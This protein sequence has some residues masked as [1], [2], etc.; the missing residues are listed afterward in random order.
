MHVFDYGRNT[1]L[2]HA[3]VIRLYHREDIEESL[4]IVTHA[5][6]S[7]VK[8]EPLPAMMVVLMILPAYVHTN[9]VNSTNLSRS[10]LD[11]APSPPT[12]TV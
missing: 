10:S 7:N 4:A 9:T 3:F 11:G 1:M 6:T 12:A 8:T 5:A 2:Y